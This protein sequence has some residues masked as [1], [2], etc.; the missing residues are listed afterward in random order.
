MDAETV[1]VRAKVIISA[2]AY[3]LHLLPFLAAVDA[4]PIRFRTEKREE[5]LDQLGFP[6]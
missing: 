6:T 1:A 5:D 3:L 4:G 2:T